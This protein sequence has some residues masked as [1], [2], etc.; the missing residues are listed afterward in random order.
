[1]N[2]EIWIWYCD[3]I[4]ALSLMLI[5]V[6]MMQCSGLIALR[7]SFKQARGKLMLSNSTVTDS[8]TFRICWMS[9]K[10]QRMSLWRQMLFSKPFFRLQFLRRSFS[11]RL[12]WYINHSIKDL[13]YN[14]NLDNLCDCI[15]I[16]TYMIIIQ[17]HTWSKFKF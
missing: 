15:I 10:T 2:T 8:S 4:R 5:E 17:S 16:I 1:M 9:Y 6:R 11:F 12:N 14:L 3:S 7:S 13:N